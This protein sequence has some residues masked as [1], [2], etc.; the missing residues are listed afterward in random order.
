MAKSAQNPEDKQSWLALAESWL[1]TV[2][3]QS[4][5]ENFQLTEETRIQALKWAAR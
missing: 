1:V 4:T 3:L 2:Q 5:P